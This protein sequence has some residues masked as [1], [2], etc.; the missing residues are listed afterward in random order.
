MNVDQALPARL[1]SLS[2][3]ICSGLAACVGPAFEGG[4]LS[5]D[6]A[7][8]DAGADVYLPPIYV[9]NPCPTDGGWDGGDATIEAAAWDAMGAE[10]G[11]A[12]LDPAGGGTTPEASAEEAPSDS[13]DAA[14]CASGQ[15]L[16]DGGCASLDDVHTC[17]LC[18][19]DCTLLPN[20]SAAGLACVQGRCVYQCAAGYSDC[21]DGGTGC[22]IY[23]SPT[24]TCVDTSSDPEDCGACGHGCQGG[25]CV[26]G[27]CQPITLFTAANPTTIFTLAVDSS[28][29]YWGSA[30]PGGASIESCSLDS[31]LPAPGRVTPGLIQPTHIA[32]DSTSIYI[33]D[34]LAGTGSN[35]LK[36][37]LPGCPAGATVFSTSSVQQTQSIAVNATSAFW[38][39][40]VGG[41]MSS[42]VVSC[43]LGGCPSSGP[44]F[45]CSGVGKIGNVALT[46][47]D[48][49]FNSA[50]GIWTCPL[51]GG[52]GN[53]V[54]A[55]PATPP[56]APAIDQ[57][58]KNVYWQ[59]GYQYIESCPI[60]GCPSGGPTVLASGHPIALVVDATDIY[61]TSALP[62]ALGVQRC[63]LAGCATPTTVATVAS[64]SFPE[65]ITQD[66]NSVYWINLNPGATYSIMKV[67]K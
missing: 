45:L 66:S 4:P 40:D 39:L 36:C 61:W 8:G 24:R 13:S 58:Y 17:G 56:G 37:P 48:L 41:A 7:S 1:F 10:A 63:A 14:S 12:T 62:S 54:F 19:N 64:G 31:C 29:V 55:A 67:A 27:K 5:D 60:E 43:P 28:N 35:V 6:G 16:C 65:S 2:F 21:I 25:A 53:N 33:V 49:V 47:T 44:T 46:P 50:S 23:C 51:T 22:G 57:Q 38:T 34:D 3:A 32:V 11:E 15:L 26:G 20:V 18:G 52:V 30:G 9:C 42:S 59:Q